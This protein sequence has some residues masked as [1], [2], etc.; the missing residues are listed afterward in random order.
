[1]RWT[2]EYD[3]FLRDFVPGHSQAEITRALE[4]LFGI[5]LT[6]SQI[7][8]RKR[9]LGVYSGTVGGRFRKGVPAKNKGVKWDVWMP[10]ESQERCR[11]TQFKKGNL[12]WNANKLK[13]G[14]TRWTVDGYIQVKVKEGHQEI[15]NENYRF[16]HHLV[17]EA[18]HG[19]IPEGCNVVFADGNRENLDPDNLVAVPRTVWSKVKQMNYRDRETLLV[20]VGI[21]KLRSKA[22]RLE[23]SARCKRSS[24]QR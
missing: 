14:D 12:P 7:S 4:E 17:Y 3:A 24:T 20:C 8:N 11:A 1:M 2:E 6:K 15:P 21:A 23:R 18:H 9:K 16:A 5:V 19:P 13:V 22:Y 10:A